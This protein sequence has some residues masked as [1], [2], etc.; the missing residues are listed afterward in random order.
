MGKRLNKKPYWL[1]GLV[2]LVIL[3]CFCLRLKKDRQLIK[4][5]G[6]KRLSFRQWEGEK[7]EWQKELRKKL[8][9]LAGVDLTVSPAAALLW[10]GEAKEENGYFDKQ[11]ELLFSE[12]KKVSCR[13]LLPESA[14]QSELPAVI[15]FPGHGEGI[16][17][18]LAEK[19]GGGLSYQQAAAQYLSQKGLITLTCEPWAFW[20]SSSWPG[21]KQTAINENL[22]KGKSILGIYIDQ[23]RSQVNFLESLEMVDPQR[24]GLAGVSFG[25][26]VSFYTAAL[27]EKIQAVFVSGFLTSYEETYFQHP[28]SLEMIIPGIYQYGEISDL[29]GLIAPR[30]V[31]FDNGET[32]NSLA[33]TAEKAEALIENEVR[34]IFESFGAKEKVKLNKASRGHVLD[35]EA[36]DKFFREAFNE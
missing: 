9:F 33:M 12:D 25:G 26:A 13:L 35:R 3:G 21:E 14:G 36:A 30:S 31:M 7:E 32:D 27:E 34:P 5:T 8:A 18:L 10:E 22:L 28:H 17:E 29:A 1:F 20:S 2:F 11:L 4:E 24:I 15:F 23:V 16:E 19:P 6:Y